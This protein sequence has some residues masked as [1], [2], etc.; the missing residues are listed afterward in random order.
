MA[1]WN[2]QKVEEAGRDDYDSIDYY[3]LGAQYKFN[4]NL[5][6]IGEYRINNLDSDD[7]GKLNTKDDFQLAA[8]YDF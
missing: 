6:V 5:R 1:L 8:R 7:S 4:K 2:K 3:T